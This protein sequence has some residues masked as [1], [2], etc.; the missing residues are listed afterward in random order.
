V[1]SGVGLLQGSAALAEIYALNFAHVG[2]ACQ[3]V[4]VVANAPQIG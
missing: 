4:E 2:K 3:L 1:N